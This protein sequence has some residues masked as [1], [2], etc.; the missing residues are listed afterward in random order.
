MTELEEIQQLVTKWNNAKKAA[1]AAQLTEREL[2]DQLVKKA[3]PADLVEGAGNKKD[4][5]H[6]MIMQ[7]TGVITRKIDLA[8]FDSLK[9]TVPQDVLDVVIRNK[10]DL[11]VGAWKKLPMS[12]KALLAP[13][14]EE[15]PGTPSIELVAKKKP[16]KGA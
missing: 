4:I 13:A 7:V 11:I 12:S 16:D 8:V 3:F 2:R 15:K 10:P 5:G 1:A 14:V 9:H 6:G